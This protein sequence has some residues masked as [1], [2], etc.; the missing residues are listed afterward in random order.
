[1]NETS[2]CYIDNHSDTCC[3]GS[4][5]IVTFKTYQVCD[6]SPLLEEYKTI[7]SVHIVTGYT[8]WD[9]NDTGITYILEF[10]K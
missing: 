1:M 7:S 8:S 6:V 10:N 9:D 3:L 2:S 5:F 4:N